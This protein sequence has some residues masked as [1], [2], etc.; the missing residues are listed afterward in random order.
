[1]VMKHNGNTWKKYQVP[2][3]WVIF[4]KEKKDV[5]LH[6]FA[7]CSEIF[8]RKNICMFILNKFRYIFP[9]LFLFLFY[10]FDKNKQGIN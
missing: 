3:S 4:K 6:A 1:M 8:T 7:N 5:I 10:F 2:Y 9:S